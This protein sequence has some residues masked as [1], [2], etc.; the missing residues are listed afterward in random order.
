MSWLSKITGIG[1]SKHGVHIDPLKAA[2]TAL[3]VGS[4]GGLGP[5]AAAGSKLGAITKLGG[6]ASK[7]GKLAAVGGFLK[8]NAKTIADYGA[9]GEG[10]YDRIQENKAA[11]EQQNRY[12]SLQPFRNQALAQLQAPAPDVH[13]LFADPTATP[14][15]YRR[16][17]VGSGGM[18]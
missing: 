18:Y 8:N 3:T 5:L 2:M 13:A 6:L 1:I 17:N 4:L 11:Q 7:G 15:R 10:V 16:V 9:V 12:R 14:D